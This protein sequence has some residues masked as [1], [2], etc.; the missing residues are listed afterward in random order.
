MFRRAMDKTWRFMWEQELI[1]VAAMKDQLLKSNW[2]VIERRIIE[3]EG[4]EP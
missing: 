3:A 4:Q 2:V 1:E